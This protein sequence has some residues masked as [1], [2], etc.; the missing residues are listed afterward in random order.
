MIENGESSLNEAQSVAVH[1]KTGPAMVVAGAGTGK[2][3]VIVERILKLIHDGVKPESILALTF[4]EK[5]A[6]EMLDRINQLRGGF[7]LDVTIATYNG[8]GD[9]ILKGYAAEIGLSNFRLLGET[10]Q[11][12]FLREH[13]DEFTLDYFAP[14]SKPDSQ[15]TLLASYVSKLKQQLVLPDRYL[16]YVDAMKSITEEEQLEKQKHEE[17]ATFYDAYIKLCRTNNVI[18][19]DDQLFLTIELLRKRPNIKKELQDRFQFV[20]VDEFQDTN[21]MQSELLSMLAG[22]HQNIMVVGDDDQSIY[23]WRGATLSNIL[24]FKNN[25][26]TAKEIT[27]IENYRSTQAILDSAYRLIQFNNPNR[28]EIMNNLNKQLRATTTGNGEQPHILH[29]TNLDNELTWVAEDIA[30]RLKSGQSPNTIAVLARR[31]QGVQRV[32]EALELHNIAHAV[33]GLS[34]DLYRQVAVNQLIEVLKCINEPEDNIALFHCLSGPLFTIDVK[35]LAEFSGISRREH[36]NLFDV[37]TDSDHEA[38]KLAIVQLEGWRS[39]THELSVGDLAYQ[40]ITESG[41]KQSLYERAEVDFEIALQVQAISQYFKTLKEFERIADIASLQNYIANLP[42]LRTAGSELR[43]ASLEISDTLVN[44]LSIHRAKGLEWETV[45]IVD[46]TEGSFP[47]RSFGSSLTIPDELM[48]TSIADEHMAEERR[49]MYVAATRARK[50]LILSFSDTHSS[51]VKR[52]PSRFLSEL[53]GHEPSG[54][55]E[56]DESKQ[57]SMELFAPKVGSEQLN[58]PPHMR[59]GNNLVLSVSQ[60]DC[61]LR[62]PQDFYYNFVLEMPQ[63]DDP[64]RA[65]GTLIHNTIENIHKSLRKGIKPDLEELLE[66]ARQKLPKSGY[67]TPKSRERSHTQALKTI[68]QLYDRFTSE[69]IPND[70]EQTFRVK[71]VE[72]PLV[73]KGRID[74]IYPHKDGVEIRDYKT[75][76]SVSTP[77]KAKSRA[78]ASMQ[79][80][81]YALAWKLMF[82]EMP[83]LLSLDFVETGVL[84]SVKKQPKSLETLTT[85]LSQMVSD[86][87]SGNYPL[88]N[89][90]TFCKHPIK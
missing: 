88:G 60:I 16:A 34:N 18:D 52:R 89:D 86:L 3:R 70:I 61:W 73:I 58:L 36:K 74:A 56:I 33:A 50:E 31:N 72:A 66:D 1:H 42:A 80:T 53:V 48:V 65:Y 84:G 10:G 14:V 30:R 12:V 68:K 79:L 49:L 11:L 71:L 5:A 2:T 59:D 29:F 47:M 75:G 55:A 85:K 82:D 23:G 78:T 43:D 8:F 28:L 40:I 87:E 17:L 62:C 35:D 57:I 54:T 9:E 37:I 41:W 81:L 22:S 46:C 67:L 13:L 24:E 15:L 26:P 6:G 69:A 77:E 4:T 76:T 25:Y 51:N 21:P 44:V 63:S 32:H 7:T 64:I 20:L 39:Q 45:Y 27:L 90:H 83:A 19:Y 38:A